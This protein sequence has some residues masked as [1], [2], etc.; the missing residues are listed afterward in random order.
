MKIRNL[1]KSIILAYIVFGINSSFDI[2]TAKEITKSVQVRY[3]FNKDGNE[4]P[5]S[6]PNWYYYW[7]QTK[8]NRGAHRYSNRN[9]VYGYYERTKNYFYVCNLAS[10]YNNETGNNGI[11]CFAETCIHENTH[12]TDW[13]GFWPNGYDPS[14]DGDGDDIPDSLEPSLGFDPTKIDTNPFD[15]WDF[16]FAAYSEPRAYAAEHTWTKGSADSEDWSAP[17][18]MYSKSKTSEISSPSSLFLEILIPISNQKIIL[19]NIPV[20]GNTNPGLEIEWKA[21]GGAQTILTTSG[22]EGT[23]VVSPFPSSNS[24]FGKNKVVTA[25]VID[26]IPPETWLTSSK[27]TPAKK[28]IQKKELYRLL[29]DCRDRVIGKIKV[30]EKKVGE[31]KEPGKASFSWDGSDNVTPNDKLEFIYY[32]ISGMNRSLKSDELPF[33]EKSVEYSLEKGAYRFYVYAID[34]AENKDPTPAEYGFAITEDEEEEIV[35]EE[36]IDPP[37]KAPGP[38][39]RPPDDNNSLPQEIDWVPVSLY[40]DIL[41]LN[42]GYV[43]EMCKLLSDL[44]EPFNLRDP[45]APL[46]LFTKYPLLIIPS[47]GLIGKSNN[48]IFR[49]K[50]RDYVSQGGTLISFAQQQGREFQALPGTPTGFGWTEDEFCFTNSVY[51]EKPHPIMSGQNGLYITGNVDGYLMSYPENSE[52]LLTRKKNY[53]PVM[54]SYPYGAGS[55]IIS[56]LYS[57]WAYSNWQWTNDEV[58]L[59]RDLITFAKNPHTPIPT[60]SPN[61]QISLNLLIPTSTSK[62]KAIVYNPGKTGSLTIEAKD[63]PITIPP[64]STL[65]IYTMDCESLNEQGSITKSFQRFA[66][67]NSYGYP[68]SFLSFSI[69]PERPDFLYKGKGSF[70]LNITNQEKD[71]RIISIYTRLNRDM[72]RFLG[73]YSISSNIEIPFEIEEVIPDYPD[74]SSYRLTIFLYENGRYLGNKISKGKIAYPKI[75]MEIQPLKP[76]YLPNDNVSLKAT[77]TNKIE[78]DY[79][80]SLNISSPFTSTKTTFILKSL[81]TNTIDYSFALNNPSPGIYPLRIEAIYKDIIVSS[82]DLSIFIPEKKISINY[83]PF[84]IKQGTNT[85]TFNIKNTG[86]I[87]TDLI[88]CKLQ[89][90]NFKLQNEKEF[91]IE[92][93]PPEG[94]TSFI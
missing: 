4:N 28:I 45:D 40:S 19:P 41:V 76:F 30:G 25:K 14:Q 11:D 52:I 46:E 44:N 53:N 79:P 18:H 27:I 26:K 49:E 56:S 55:V 89:I 50:L 83:N 62:I 22:V 20:K 10:G 38:S 54:I 64:Q 87:P 48:P 47:G 65:G 82:K 81:E 80:I 12:L 71:Q 70:N 77:I 7:S 1:S 86:I 39:C 72:P 42:S 29:L 17:G 59:I 16:D 63:N 75:D 93:L 78:F 31:R 13:W 57:D 23:I 92:P 67:S 66:V 24:G 91:T 90:L 9:D 73:T 6:D 8:A 68:P 36:I 61:Q 2:A 94:T 15:Q 69:I 21:D 33:P 58:F 74:N 88:N 60:F 37:L 35:G 51:I 3:F 43:K 34:E 32:L 5:S 85:I 84:T